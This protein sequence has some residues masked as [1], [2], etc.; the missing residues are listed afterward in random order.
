MNILYIKRQCCT[1]ADFVIHTTGIWYMWNH[2]P[3][4]SQCGSNTHL[5]LENKVLKTYKKKKKRFVFK[6]TSKKH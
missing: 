5:P 3:R 6:Q 2:E 1:Q 4:T